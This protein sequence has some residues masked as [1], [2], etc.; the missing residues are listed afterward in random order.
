VNPLR[1]EPPSKI[2]WIGV[3]ASCTNNDAIVY[4]FVHVM[5]FTNDTRIL[6]KNLK[7]DKY[8]SARQLLKEWSRS[9]VITPSTAAS[10][11]DN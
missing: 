11:N 6:L 7:Q 8:Y 9:L 3:T 5:L 4:V 1:H 2:C 10:I